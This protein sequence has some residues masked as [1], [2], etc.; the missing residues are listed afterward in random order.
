MAGLANFSV[1]YDIYNLRVVNANYIQPFEINTSH[2]AYALLGAYIALFMMVSLFISA[3]LIHRR[4]L[5]LFK[6]LR[7]AIIHR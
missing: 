4:D 6:L 3:F 2:L 5:S 7:G 1:R